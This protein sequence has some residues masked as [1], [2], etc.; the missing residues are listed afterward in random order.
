MQRALPILRQLQRAGA[1]AAEGTSVR[2]Y[3]TLGNFVFSSLQDAPVSSLSGS[4]NVSVKAGSGKGK[5]VDVSVSAGSATVKAKY[6]AADLRKLAAKELALHDVARVSVL[7]SSF[8]DYLVKLAN[9]RYK[10]LA[11]WPDFTTAYGKDYYYRAHPEDLKKFYAAVDEFHRIYD[12]ITE[13][14]S[15]SGLAAE[16]LPAYRKKRLNTIHPAVG[17]T[18][19]NAVVTQFLLSKAA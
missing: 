17:P 13:F 9:D 6:G 5:N 18:T 1:E 12:V 2:A 7:H 3:S 14:E 19:S 11:S 15:L 4:I 16:L 8:M 10:I